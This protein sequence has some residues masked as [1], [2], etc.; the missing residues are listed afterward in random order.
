[1]HGIIAWLFLLSTYL[2]TSQMAKAT[3]LY[4]LGVQPQ[5]LM[6]YQLVYFSITI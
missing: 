1:M 4:Y 6:L 5:S 2:V 3:V